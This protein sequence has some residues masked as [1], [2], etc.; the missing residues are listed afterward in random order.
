MPSQRKRCFSV[1]GFYATSIL[2]L[3]GFGKEWRLDAN[4]ASEVRMTKNPKRRTHSTSE[5]K[6]R[7]TH[8][9]FANLVPAG[10]A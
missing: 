8:L 1:G 2:N 6:P 10:L 4:G 9:R 5:S 7:A 3:S